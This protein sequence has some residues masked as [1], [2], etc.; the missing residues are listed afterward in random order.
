VLLRWVHGTLVDSFLLAYGLYVRPLSPAERDAYCAESAGIETLLGMPG[1]WLP[2]SEAE[3]GRYMT[4]MLA[5]PELR[6]TD[7]ARELARAVLWPPRSALA[8]P[9][10]ATM[11]LATI[12]LLPA[13]LR[14]AYG[15]AWDGR[16][17]AALRACA[18]LVRG[19]LP[20][21]PPPLRY[22]P[23]ARA[24]MRRPML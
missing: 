11:R 24:A 15:F 14:D 8:W 6:V 16:R 3:L 23:A 4:T 5:G 10:L 2:R 12:G 20:L 9:A 7:T 17:A 13:P 1:G 21:T 22:W 19:A 18:A